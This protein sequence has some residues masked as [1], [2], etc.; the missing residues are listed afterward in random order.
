MRGTRAGF[1]LIELMITVAIVGII[2]GLALWAYSTYIRKARAS[3]VPMVFGELASKE[4]AYAAERGRYLGL[5]ATDPARPTGT[6]DDG[7]VEGDF[8][9]AS[10]EG[11][12]KTPIEPLLGRWTMLKAQNYGGL[13][14]QYNV[15][16]GLANDNTGMGAEGAAL[17]NGA[18]PT[19][20]WFYMLAQCDTNGNGI[21]ATYAQRGDR[22]DL[23]KDN[24][25]E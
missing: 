2:A 20:N 8:W 14:C 12:S 4:E 17:W 7:C 6:A 3:E 1:S 11:A 15:V 24:D 5:C 9:P 23:A 19:R 21:F 13:Y 18:T 16:A 25:G 22:T 10:I